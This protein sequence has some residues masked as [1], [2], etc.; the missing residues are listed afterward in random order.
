MNGKCDQ[1]RPGLDVHILLYGSYHLCLFAI[2][3]NLVEHLTCGKCAKWPWLYLI[4]TF[5][6]YCNGI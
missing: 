3:Q 4:A 5:S 1:M 6:P 2:E